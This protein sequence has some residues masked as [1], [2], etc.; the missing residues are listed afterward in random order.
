[1]YDYSNAVT[2]EAAHDECGTRARY[3]IPVGSYAWDQICVGCNG[4]VTTNRQH[5]HVV[6]EGQRVE[7]DW[8][9]VTLIECT[10][11][12]VTFVPHKG[13]LCDLHAFV[14][15]NSWSW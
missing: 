11:S 2:V 12:A 7:I 15:L 8:A 13:N 10:A 5:A 1:M 4:V 9:G 14:A 6:C 3:V